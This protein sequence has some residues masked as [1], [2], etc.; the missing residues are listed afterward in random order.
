MA[1]QVLR[2]QWAYDQ[3]DIDGEQ[4]HPNDQRPTRILIRKGNATYFGKTL[5]LDDNKEKEWRLHS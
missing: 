3:K 1:D 5:L 2:D 4:W